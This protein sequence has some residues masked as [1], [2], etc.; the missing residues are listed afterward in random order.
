ML[1]QSHTVYINVSL[2]FF[3]FNLIP[4]PGRQFVRALFHHGKCKLILLIVQMF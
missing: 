2:I 1:C 3:L 4:S